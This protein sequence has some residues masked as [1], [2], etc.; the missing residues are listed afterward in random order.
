MTEPKHKIV[1][2]DITEK[3]KNPRQELLNAQE[4]QKTFIF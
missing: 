2:Q 4:F 3:I 1:V